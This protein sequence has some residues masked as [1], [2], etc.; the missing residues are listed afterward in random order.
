[1]LPVRTKKNKKPNFFE[2]LQEDINNNFGDNTNEYERDE[3]EEAGDFEREV[4]KA[5]ESSEDLE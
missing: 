1:M 3:M 2:K 4:E 5:M